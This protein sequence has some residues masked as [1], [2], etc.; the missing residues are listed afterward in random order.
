MKIDFLKLTFTILVVLE[1]TLFILARQI[2]DHANGDQTRLPKTFE[3]VDESQLKPDN[4][5]LRSN[6]NLDGFQVITTNLSLTCLAK[7][8]CTSLV[9]NKRITCDD[10]EDEDVQI[11]WFRPVQIGEYEFYEPKSSRILFSNPQKYK[12]GLNSYVIKSQ[13]NICDIGALHN[14]SYS[15]TQKILGKSIPFDLL[16]RGGYHY[17]VK[18]F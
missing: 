12:I 14:G 1:S 9:V 3:E 13:M 16:V 7:F 4:I 2:R 15:C 5:Y 18:I 11:I 8:N 17:L 10:L 6:V